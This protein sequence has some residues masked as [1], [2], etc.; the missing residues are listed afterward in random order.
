MKRYNFFMGGEGSG[1]S[2]FSL[3][4]LQPEQLLFYLLSYPFPL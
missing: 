2:E 3:A 1:V 4:L